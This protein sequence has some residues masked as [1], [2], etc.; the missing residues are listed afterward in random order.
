MLYKKKR[1]PHNFPREIWNAKNVLTDENIKK[2]WTMIIIC[3]RSKNIQGNEWYNVKICQAYYFLL[4]KNTTWKFPTRKQERE[5]NIFI[6]LHG[7]KIRRRR[8]FPV[9]NVLNMY[10][11]SCRNFSLLFSFFFFPPS[12]LFFFFFFFSFSFAKVL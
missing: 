11:I 12:R 1:R 2:E 4:K 3:T 10:N 7:K 9:I 6:I 5:E 8:N